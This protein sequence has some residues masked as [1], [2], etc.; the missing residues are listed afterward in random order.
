MP[1]PLL[2]RKLFS[3]P[4]KFKYLKALST[5]TPSMAKRAGSTFA[6]APM[7]QGARDGSGTPDV[8]SVPRG[9]V[10]S[11]NFYANFDPYQGGGACFW[12]P[13]F[14]KAQTYANEYLW[15]AGA[16][17]RLYY[18]AAGSFVLLWGGQSLTVAHTTVAGTRIS[19]AW[20][21]SCINTLDG[22]NYLMLSIN[23]TQTYGGTTLPTASASGATGAV[24]SYGD[25]Y[26]ANGLIEGLVF[27][28]R[29]L[30]T[31]AYGVDMS[32]GVDEVAA[33]RAA[34]V[35]ADL[36]LTTGA[37]DVVLSGPTD[38]T[39]GALVTNSTDFWS[40]PSASQLLTDWH[41]MSGWAAAAYSTVGTPAVGPAD[42]ADATKVY[43]GGYSFTSDAANEGIAQTKAGL[44]AGNSYRVRVVAH[45]TSADAIRL[46]VYDNIGAAAILSYDFGA[47][48]TRAAPGHAR[49]LVTLPA[50][51]TSID[52]RV[53]SSGSQT[54]YVHSIEVL[55]SLWLDGGMELGTAVTNVG[56][57]GTSAQ[58]NEQAHSGTYSW[59]V[60]TDAIDEGISR[61]IGVTSGVYY[62]VSAWVYAATAN[63]V[64]MQVAG[65]VLQ[66]GS[67]TP[68][69]TTVNDAW[70]RLTGVVR[71]TGA[72]LTVS[73]LSNAAVQTFYVDD[74]SV[75]A[76]TAMTLAATPASAANS[77]ESGGLRV[78][79]YDTLTQPIPAG[80]LKASS[81][82]ILG[83]KLV[84][85]HAPADL[86]K[87]GNAY[88]AFMTAQAADTNNRIRLYGEAANTIT[89]YV[90]YG[91][92]NVGVS[93]ACAGAWVVGDTVQFA[94]RHTGSYVQL[95]CFV[96]G[97]GGVK[98][99]ITGSIAFS[100]IPTTAYWMTTVGRAQ[101]P[102]AVILE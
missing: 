27:Y 91:G 67:T 26:P 31:G 52:V 93:W 7:V 64:D 4:L 29:P 58:S 71:A 2:I 81:G 25:A 1:N 56:T 49:V 74:V 10:V 19:L 37:D 32:N 15:S 22:T 28:R 21:G 89:L 9:D 48:S 41:M 47:S 101:Q 84:M 14:S 96:N 16:S 92:V 44:T 12:T 8:L 54:V 39:P 60:I 70:Q 72:N 38:G 53:L 40:S 65:G 30:W 62:H 82:Y 61:V 98:E 69:V 87:F 18:S 97:V 11:G 66:T 46:V 75:V 73:F 99:T 43:S 68:R 23:D 13:E 63:T 59:K 50:G 6:A 78:D 76:L 88:V 80:K 55:P 34:G 36:A 33:H 35:G 86:V 5:F 17:Y 83:P 77:A 94:I 51:C 102:D 79:G 57:P 24:G 90:S 45:C 85:R 95:I 20:A 100:A 3:T 42:Q